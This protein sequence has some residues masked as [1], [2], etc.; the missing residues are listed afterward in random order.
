MVRFDRVTQDRLHAALQKV[1]PEARIRPSEVDALAVALWRARAAGEELPPDLARIDLS[2]YATPLA[3]LSGTLSASAGEVLRAE[4]N[5]PY[6]YY[7]VKA[8]HARQSPGGFPNFVGELAM[9]R[10][11]LPARTPKAF[12]TKIGSVEPGDHLIDTVLE[13]NQKYAR[14]LAAPLGRVDL[15]TPARQGVR[16]GAI[17]VLL[18][19]KKP[20]DA[21]PFCYILEAG[22]ATGQPKVLYLGK[23]IGAT[24]NAYSGY[25]PTPF[26]CPNHA[27]L[28]KFQ[29]EGDEPK[30]LEVAARKIEAGVSQAPYMKL[31]VRFEREAGAIRS[32]WP[33]F[34]IARAASIVLFREH[35]GT[36]A[37]DCA[38]PPPGEI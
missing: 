19:Y 7:W 5:D 14:F 28:G 23:T 4:A 38:L 30:Q 36:I 15:I 35:K 18:G 11:S 20:R 37:K 24:I 25:Q 12:K 32:I 8:E 1:F 26:S 31:T 13:A 34:L 21:Q 2:A 9:V 6:R 17:S 22:T 29:L 3:E 16:F 27:Y 33:G 10:V